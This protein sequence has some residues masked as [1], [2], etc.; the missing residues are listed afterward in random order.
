[1]LIWSSGGSDSKASVYKCRRPGFNPCVRKIPGSRKW[2][3][4]PVLLLGKS[5]GWRS[6]VGYSPWGRRE[7]DMTEQLHF[8]T[9]SDQMYVINF[10]ALCAFFQNIMDLDSFSAQYSFPLEK[11]STPIW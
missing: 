1:M 10:L 2:Q 3:P 4:T 11:W 6:M 5:H 8:F 9:S 7:S